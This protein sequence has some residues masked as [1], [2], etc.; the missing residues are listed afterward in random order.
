M[1]KINAAGE[2]ILTLHKLLLQNVLKEVSRANISL[3]RDIGVQNLIRAQR[4]ERD[5]LSRPVFVDPIS[6]VLLLFRNTN[7]YKV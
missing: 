2:V 1:L 6:L 5:P 7:V 4:V 3:S